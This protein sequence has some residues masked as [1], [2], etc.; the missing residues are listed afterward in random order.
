M[1]Q[2]V[3]K[4]LT[5]VK[6]RIQFTNQ[7]K[8]ILFIVGFWRSGTTLMTNVFGQSPDIRSFHEHSKR[9]HDELYR[10][11][12]NEELKA[13]IDKIIEPWIVF[14]P[15]NDAHRIKDLMQIHKNTKAVWVYRHYLDVINSGQEMWPGHWKTIIESLMNNDRSRDI[16]DAIADS[17]SDE[18]LAVLARFWDKEITDNDGAALLWYMRNQFFFENDLQ[19]NPDILLCRYEEF[20]TDPN[21]EFQRIFDFFECPYSPKYAAQ[22]HT[23]SIRKNAPPILHPEIEALCSELLA[24]FDATRS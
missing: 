9:A 8:R 10:I 12:S 23:S 21:H 7:P 18:S 19:A 17:I 16:D 3:P 20:V 6:R 15:L 2:S 1:F 5:K 14:K 4:L 24:R 11:R 22:V 13:L